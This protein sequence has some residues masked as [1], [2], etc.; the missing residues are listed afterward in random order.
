L[1]QLRSVEKGQS[2]FLGAVTWSANSFVSAPVW[3]FLTGYALATVFVNGIPSAS[4]IVNVGVLG[5]IAPGITAVAE[6]GRRCR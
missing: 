4:S 6:G 3:N 5:P 1:V 2:T